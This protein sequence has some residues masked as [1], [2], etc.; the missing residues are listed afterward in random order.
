MTSS[1]KITIAVSAR[2]LFDFEEENPL[3]LE[4]DH[5]RNCESASR[6]VATGRVPYGINNESRLVLH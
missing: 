6:L 3:F 5:V 1:T 4:S 2:T